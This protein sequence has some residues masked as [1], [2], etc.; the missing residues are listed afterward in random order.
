MQ[1]PFFYASS[2]LTISSLDLPIS[3]GDTPKVAGLSRESYIDGIWNKDSVEDWLTE[4]QLP[5]E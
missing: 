1:F 5:I 4:V 3:E 2:K